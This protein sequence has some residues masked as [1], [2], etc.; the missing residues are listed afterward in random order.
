MIK[1]YFIQY[2]T[3]ELKFKNEN[4]NVPQKSDVCNLTSLV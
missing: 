1:G 4:I 2:A 3:I